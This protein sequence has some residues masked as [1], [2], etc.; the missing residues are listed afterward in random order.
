MPLMMKAPASVTMIAG[1]CSRTTMRP[2]MAPM[3][4]PAATTAAMPPATPSAPVMVVAAIT[5]PR[6][7]VA[8]IARLMPPVSMRIACAIET[9]ASGNQLWANFEMPP[10]LRKPG[11]R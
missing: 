9:S 11:K 3:A 8:P 6:L 7:T 4:R 5:A 1:R 10:T 2:E